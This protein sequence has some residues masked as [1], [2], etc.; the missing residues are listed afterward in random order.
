VYSSGNVSTPRYQFEQALCGYKHVDSGGRAANN[1]G[2]AV[3]NKL[4]FERVHKFSIA[5]ENCVYP[6]YSTEK[7]VES[8]AAATV[9]LYY[10]DPTIERQFNPNAFLNLNGC[11]DVDQMV[12]MVKELDEDDVRYE[13]M[14]RQPM[15]PPDSNLPKYEALDRFVLNAVRWPRARRRP[16][17][18]AWGGGGLPIL[19]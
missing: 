3:E 16:P 15:L 1:I 5:F 4:T 7:I 11:A 10:G 6:G 8:F 13:Y 9:P 18:N 17:R 19:G 2:Y 14:L 12:S